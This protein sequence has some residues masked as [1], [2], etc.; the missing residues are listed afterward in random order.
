MQTKGLYVKFEDL[1]KSYG[2]MIQNIYIDLNGKR[3]KMQTRQN[4][5]QGVFPDL[6]LASIAFC[7]LLVVTYLTMRYDQFRYLKSHNCFKNLR[8]SVL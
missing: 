6:F 1:P 7:V 8:K 5:S 3:T 4:K 2:F